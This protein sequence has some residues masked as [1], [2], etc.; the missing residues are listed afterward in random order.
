MAAVGN[1]LNHHKQPKKPHTLSNWVRW[2]ASGDVKCLKCCTCCKL[3]VG[4]H[5]R[6]LGDDGTCL[7]EINNARKKAGLND[8]VIPQAETKD[9]RLPDKGEEDSA[10]YAEWVW[11]PVCDVLIP[12]EAAGKSTEAEA[13]KKFM[14]GTYAF[15]VVDA[16]SLSCTAV[17]EKWKNAY[18]NFNGLP[19]PNKDAEEL[20]TSRD[21]ISFVAMYNPSADA[22]ADCR[23]V[24]CTRKIATVSAG[25]LTE[26][27]EEEEG[28][29]PLTEETKEGSALI[30]MTTPDVL[31]ANSDNPPFT[32][33][34]WGQIVTAFE[35]SASAVLPSLLGL[36]AALLGVAA[37][38]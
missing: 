31:P 22:T 35:G 21:N 13:G 19:P 8:F 5:Y 26:M 23:V 1:R 30:C 36:A 15:Q 2:L 17:V 11:K 28:E 18:S 7:S 29:D 10:T 32:E 9:K 4:G 6:R 24:T 37:A 27:G 20:Y 14:S 16:A 3:R 38:L 12:Q 34:Q 25:L 33:E